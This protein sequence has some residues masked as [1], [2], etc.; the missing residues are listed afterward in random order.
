MFFYEERVVGF[1]AD[2]EDIWPEFPDD[3]LSQIIWGERNLDQY[4][5]VLVFRTPA[6]LNLS[7][8]KQLYVTL[9]TAETVLDIWIFFTNYHDKEK[10]KHENF[11][12]Y[13]KGTF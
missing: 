4:S 6:F 11:V 2:L 10:F 3:L 12:W 13:Q 8:T 7:K 9:K 1:G 5:A